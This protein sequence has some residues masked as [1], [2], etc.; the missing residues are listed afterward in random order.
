MRLRYC[1]LVSLVLLAAC[2]READ[3]A[4][5][6]E[7]KARAERAA[8]LAYE[9]EILA[10][11]DQRVAR[12]TRPDGWLSLV[13]LHWI[14]PGATYVGAAQD[15]GTRLAIGPP[16]VGMVSLS[17]EGALT[18]RIAPDA[19]VTI[20]GEPASGTVALLADSQ[21]GGPT[22]VGFNRGDAS[23]VVIER[24]GR[25]GLRVRSALAPTRTGFPGLDYFDIDPAFRFTAR[26]QAHPPGKTLEIINV[27][28]MVEPMANPGWVEFDKDGKTFRMEAVDEGDGQLFFIF[29]DRTS[30]HATY[31]A[32]RFVYAQPA[33]KDGTTTLD[34]NTAYNPPCAFVAYSTCPMPPPE[35]RLDLAVTA[36]EK[37]P[38][39]FPE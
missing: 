35:N 18:L 32:A 22:V 33:G 11:R 8:R 7:T 25:F 13:G 34:F 36:G 23:F 3:D 1:L 16:Q 28:G 38:R 21:E 27:L 14:T 19:E 15:N 17:D 10:W 12:L 24:V 39:P 6:S 26:F 29:A 31:A 30:G 37:K 2:G 5:Q 9:G 4:A 20:N